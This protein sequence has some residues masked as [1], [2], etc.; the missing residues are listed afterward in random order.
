MSLDF[1]AMD[2]TDHGHVPYVIILVRV[3]EEWKRSVRF[4]LIYNSHI[5]Y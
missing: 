1:N 2:P 5:T 3:L 4:S